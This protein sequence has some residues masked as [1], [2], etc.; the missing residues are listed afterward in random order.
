[1]LENA[2]LVAF[3]ATAK[4]DDCR[5][6]Y[7]DTLGLLFVGDDGRSLIF[8]S[9]GTALRVLKVKEVPRGTR[10]VLGWEVGDLLRLMRELASRGVAFE[11]M[12][13]LP[14]DR[15]GIWTG[16]DGTMMAWFRDPDGNLLS[17][18]EHA[19]LA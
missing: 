10:A 15:S 12:E 14:Q 17:L 5:R 4:P 3:A 2:N 6:F 1:M 7:H 19:E 8:D 9:N 13:G 18:S 11:R 16:H